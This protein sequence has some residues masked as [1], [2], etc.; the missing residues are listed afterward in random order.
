[1]STPTRPRLLNRRATLFAAI[2]AGAA[3]IAGLATLGASAADN[4]QA[5]AM[6]RLM[7]DAMCFIGG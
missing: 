4:P 2:A 6:P 1:M 5:R 3:A 7:L